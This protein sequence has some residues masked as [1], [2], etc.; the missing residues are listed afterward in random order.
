MKNRIGIR[1]TIDGRWGGIREGL[2]AQTMQ[3]AK[4][5]KKYIR[6]TFLHAARWVSIFI[7]A[8]PKVTVPSISWIPPVTV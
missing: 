2:E 5:A 8:E 4:D 1:P 6:L 3:M 7:P